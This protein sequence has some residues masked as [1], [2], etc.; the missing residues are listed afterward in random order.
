MTN[1]AAQTALGDIK[2]DLVKE[3]K[4]LS[5][6]VNIE[7]TRSYWMEIWYCYGENLYNKEQR[8]LN[9]ELGLHSVNMSENS[10]N[11]KRKSK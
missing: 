4:N 11:F 9:K 1:S 5:S 8:A 3:H 2:A 10:K 7:G 6:T